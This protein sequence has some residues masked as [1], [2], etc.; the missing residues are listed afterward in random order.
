MK[1]FS[2]TV[3]EEHVSICSEPGGDYLHHFT[4]DKPTSGVTYA[5]SVA[6]GLMEFLTSSKQEKNILAIGGDSTNVNTGWKGGAIHLLEVGLNRRLVWI[7]CY[8]HLNELPL[9]HLIIK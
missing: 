1:K 6:N 7:V 3:N 4:P 9:R 2:G 5:Q 8:L